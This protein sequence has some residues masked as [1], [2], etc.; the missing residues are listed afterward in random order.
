MSCPVILEKKKKMKSRNETGKSFLSST[1]VCTKFKQSLAYV[2][3]VNFLHL[4]GSAIQ[5]NFEIYR[6]QET[7]L[8]P[9]A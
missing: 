4:G 1:V 9:H 5:I 2:A 6:C 3:V 7:A 8:K